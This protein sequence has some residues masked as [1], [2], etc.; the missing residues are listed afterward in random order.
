[1]TLPK[2]KP[3]PVCSNHAHFRLRKGN[4][5]YHQCTSCK[6][7]FSDPLPNDNMVGGGNEIGRN[8]EQNHLRIDRINKMCLGMK[9]E[10]AYI[11]DFGC[12]HG[13]LMK[14]LQNAGYNCDGYDAYNDEFSRLPQKNKY[15]IVTAIEVIEHTSHPFAELDVIHRSLLPEGVLMIET[16]FVDIAH[17]EGIE[18]EDF[19]YIDPAVGHST[20]FS[21]HGLDVLLCL[22]GFKPISHWNRHVRAYQ[23]V[24]R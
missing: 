3:C 5:D 2:E 8:V 1:M 20:I 11:L 15:H 13:M 12:G 18:Y 9:K 23:K 14:D 6:T 4:T 19:F 16:S 17:M 24:S 22:K 21:H 7:L 10:D